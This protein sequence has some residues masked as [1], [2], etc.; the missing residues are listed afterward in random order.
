VM[1]W[2]TFTSLQLSPD[3]L[4][5]HDGCLV[6]FVGDRVEVRGYIELR[7]TFSD[8]TSAKTIDVRYIVVN[9]SSAYNL[10]LG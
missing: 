4:R 9:A 7:T 2:S 1:F 5:S 3:Q 6:G 8:G 10:L